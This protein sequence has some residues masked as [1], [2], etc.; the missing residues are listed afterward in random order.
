MVIPGHQIHSY[1]AAL[2]ETIDY[3][4]RNPRAATK[5][6]LDASKEPVTLDDA[7]AMVTDP[8]TKL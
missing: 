6:Y 7:V 3:I 8:E 5:D 4:N 2:S 1:V